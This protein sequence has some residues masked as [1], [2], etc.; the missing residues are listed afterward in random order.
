MLPQPVLDALDTLNASLASSPMLRVALHAHWKSAGFHAPVRLDAAAAA[1]AA[2][3]EDAWGAV[4]A[5]VARVVGARER[6]ARAIGAID[7][8]GEA[9]AARYSEALAELLRTVA[10]TA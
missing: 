10:E 6:L 5:E 7:G 2:V 9:R 8:L 3:L 1:A 4:Q